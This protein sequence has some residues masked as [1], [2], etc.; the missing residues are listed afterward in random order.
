MPRE[1][2][3]VPHS[4]AEAFNLGEIP[5]RSHKRFARLR[6]GQLAA[7]PL[8]LPERAPSGVTTYRLGAPAYLVG[9]F[10]LVNTFDVSRA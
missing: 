8:Y 2:K 10:F 7:L 1:S 4:A 5:L 6:L 3:I 9:A